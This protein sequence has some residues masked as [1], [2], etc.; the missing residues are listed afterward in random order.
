MRKDRIE[1][2]QSMLDSL[3]LTPNKALGQNFLVDDVAISRILDAADVRGQAVL[4]IGPGAGALTE[5]LLQSA[6]TVAAVEIDA[7]MCALLR[8]RFGDALLLYNEDFLKAD[9]SAI[10]RAL[11]GGAFCVTGN[12]PYYITTPVCMRLLTSELPISRMT[13]MVQQEAAVRF[14]ALP[15]A[16][17]YGP[18]SVL[19][20][21]YYTPSRV[22]EL[23][24]ESYYPQPDVN[25]SVVTLLRNAQPFLPNLAS[26]LKACFAMRRKTI[27]NN[28]KGYGGKQPAMDALA[29]CGI[30]PAARA[31][32]LAPEQFVQLCEQL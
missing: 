13:L 19:T 16:R 20:Q 8:A 26:L 27:A 23:S 32:T 3:S 22:M 2:L 28:L 9:L 6:K 15:G 18:M 24:P 30:A 1:Q 7:R 5:G 14:F 11:C 17:V 31:E 25:S 29:A 21:V 4:E 10:H 12:L